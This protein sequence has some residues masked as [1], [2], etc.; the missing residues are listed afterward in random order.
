MSKLDGEYKLQEI[1]AANI[2]ETAEAGWTMRNDGIDKKKVVQYVG[3]SPAYAQRALTC[4]VQLGIMKKEG[5]VY[6]TVDEASK[7]SRASKDQ[8]PTLFG[9]FL[10]RYPPFVLFVAQVGRGDSVDAAARKIAAVY[11]FSLDATKTRR[12]LVGWGTYSN[13]FD[14]KDDGSLVIRA[15]VDTLDA[16]TV[17]ELL[18]ATTSELNARV[19]I[20]NR[21]GDDAFV[22]LGNSVKFFVSAILKHLDDPRNSVE[23][24]GKGF[25]DYLR[26]LCTDHG[27]DTSK[28]NGIGGLTQV[29]FN[30]NHILD[31]HRDISYGINAIRIASAH[32]IDKKKHE[33]WSINAECAIETT[34]LG[35]TMIRSIYQYSF[36]KEMM[37]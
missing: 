13:L 10:V 11:D 36:M 34:L 12:V 14:E 33:L 7:V 9:S 28:I 3:I 4:A 23:D 19:Y 26:L 6:R 17:R 8:W 21:I 2:M 16:E 27:I 25:E 15:N 29:L 22:Y 5:Q 31:K 20:T 35:L 1:T 32:G 30:K 24:A 37:M 18:K